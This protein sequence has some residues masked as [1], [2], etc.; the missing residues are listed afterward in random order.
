MCPVPLSLADQF[1]IQELVNRMERSVDDRDADAWVACFT[2]EGSFENPGG[3]W[4]GEDTHRALIAAQTELPRSQ[5]LV[6]NLLIEGD[7]GR[8]TVR[9]NGAVLEEVDG[10]YTL[11]NFAT[12][13]H[14]LTR[15]D[16]HWLIERTIRHRPR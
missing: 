14:H 6:T 15:V 9:A 7:D 12:Q 16:G 11:S 2:T 13:E 8:A 4:A 3:T 5:H 1:A 10:V